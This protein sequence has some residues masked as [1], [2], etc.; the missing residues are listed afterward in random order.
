VFSY[1][2]FF[3]KAL[4]EHP[5]PKPRPSSLGVTLRFLRLANGWS[6]EELARALGIRPVLISGYERGVKTLSQERLEKLL[7]IMEGAP[8]R[9]PWPCGR[10]RKTGCPVL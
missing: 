8:E 6:G 4:R 10:L 7:A 5:M 1:T 9:P 3:E 2:F